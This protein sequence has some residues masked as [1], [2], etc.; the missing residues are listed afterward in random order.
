MEATITFVITA[1]AALALLGMG[2]VLSRQKEG[3]KG[4]IT[5]VL[6]F[7]FLVLLLLHMSKFKH[8]KGFGFDAET[9]DEKQVEAAKLVDQLSN[10][11]EVL[12]QQI[13]LLSSRLGMW[14]SGLTTPE[15]MDIYKQTEKQLEAAS[16]SKPRRDEILEPLRRRIVLGYWFTV[17]HLIDDAYV[18]QYHTMLAQGQTAKAAEE[19]TE[20]VNVVEAIPLDTFL[21]AGSFDPVISV[22]RASKLFT[23]PDTL[24]KNLAELNDDLKYFIVNRDLRRRI[25]P[26]ASY[27]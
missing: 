15:L 6:T 14:D 9:W 8:V 22:V 16:I 1:L 2:I 17:R 7:G 12:S 26:S 21:A 25:E 27:P 20:R 5:A 24:L 4:A 18:A 23:A 19:Q 3:S 13:V 10:M 11:S